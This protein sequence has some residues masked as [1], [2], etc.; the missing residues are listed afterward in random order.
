MKAQPRSKAFIRLIVEQ[1]RK[2]LQINNDEKVDVI[3]L[4]EF[5]ICPNMEISLQIVEEK[6]MQDKYAEYSPVEQTI[7][8]REDVYN[9]AIDGVGR[10]RFTISH[11]IGHIFLHSNNI[12]MARSNEQFPI[13]CDPEWQANVF[14][15]EFLC[16]LI[17][18]S[19]NDNVDDISK[20]Y[21]V[22]KEVA[23]IQLSEKK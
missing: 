20:K 1:I 4:L 23:S 12:A 21:G 16:P 5:V 7:K 18:I 9:R 6:Y 14:A 22:S 13:Y 8:I 3:R 11:E 2:I 15:R 17:G 10:D 19:K